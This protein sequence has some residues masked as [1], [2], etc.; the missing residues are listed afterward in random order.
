MQKIDQ[1]MQKLNYNI[2]LHK[3]KIN[4][5]DNNK[6]YSQDNY[7]THNIQQFKREILNN[8]NQMQNEYNTMQKTKNFLNNNILKLQ[9]MKIAIN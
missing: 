3:N 9:D 1:G 6:K 5:L 4:Q 2:A 8:I 7:Q